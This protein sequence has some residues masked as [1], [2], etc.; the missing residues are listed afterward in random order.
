MSAPRRT[1]AL[2]LAALLL[3]LAARLL[4]TAQEKT[5]TIDEPHYVAKGLYLW[6]TGDYH[7]FDTLRLHPPLTYHIASLP[8]LLL[9]L[10]GL[11]HESHA[12]LRLVSRA[13]T[14]VSDNK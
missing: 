8:L 5:F 6:R 13:L 2:L 9:D 7:W 3:L 1:T 14:V 12:G 11:G 4:H 10:E